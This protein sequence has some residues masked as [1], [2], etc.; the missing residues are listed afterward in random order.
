MA[1]QLLTVVQS[2][3]AYSNA[4]GVSSN[5]LQKS[6]DWT[7]RLQNLTVSA[8]TSDTDVVQPAQE[9]VLFDGTQAMSQALNPSN[10]VLTLV[11]ISNTSSNYRLN[12]DAGDGLFRVRRAVQSTLTTSSSIAVTVNNNAIANFVISGAGSFAAAQVGDILKI[13]GP[14]TGDSSGNLFNPINSGYWVILNASSTTITARR[15]AGQPFSGVSET[16]LLSS[17]PQTHLDVY[18]AQGVQ[19]GDTLNI[20]GSTL[21]SSSA[22]QYTVTQVSPTS[23][24]FV[25][26]NPLAN[27]SGVSVASASDILFY[28]N[29]KKLVYIESDQ[30]IAIKYNLDT[31]ENNRVDPIEVGSDY[32]PGYSHKWGRT[33]SCSVKNLSQVDIANIKY[34]FAE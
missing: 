3:L 11:L 14:S 8:V 34:I 12:I 1:N 7:S 2:I 18:S 10:S 32:L 17:N 15:M 13:K 21:V 20:S 23:I 22:G 27:Q 4:Q 16:V 28:S 19:L 30:P 33:W 6:A 25:S 5:P 9:I 29:A 24:D 26:A 31:S